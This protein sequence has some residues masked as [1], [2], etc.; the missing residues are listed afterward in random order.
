MKFLK[1][2]V[3]ANAGDTVEVVLEGHAANVMLL[4]PLNFQN[5]ISGR[6][7]HYYGGYYTQSPAHITVPQQGHW[8]LVIDLGGAAGHVSASMRVIPRQS[9]SIFD[10]AP[11]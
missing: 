4:D 8:Y 10:P 9:S 11:G 3:D 2:E 5:Y 1:H 6:A 7:F